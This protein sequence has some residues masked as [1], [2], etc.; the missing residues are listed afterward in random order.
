M[1]ENLSNVGCP[2]I[3]KLLFNKLQFLKLDVKYNHQFR[4]LKVRY[5]D[6]KH[7]TDGPAK[8]IETAMSRKQHGN[9]TGGVG[10]DN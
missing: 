6:W 5:F 8:S 7:Q 4:I 10:G 2:D 1:R 3:R 9:G